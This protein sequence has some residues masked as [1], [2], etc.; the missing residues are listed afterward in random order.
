VASLQDVIKM[1]ILSSDDDLIEG[2]ARAGGTTTEHNGDNSNN[3]SN[4]VEDIGL[5]GDDQLGQY[6]DFH[7]IDWQ[8]DS[9]RDRMRHRFI[10]RKKSDSVTNY[11]KVRLKVPICRC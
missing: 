3:G 5:V 4:G 11:V 6:D 1:D 9:A 8:R 2:I 7:T 10:A